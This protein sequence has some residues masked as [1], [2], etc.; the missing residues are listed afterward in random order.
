[1]S[2]RLDNILSKYTNPS[3]ENHVPLAIAA[4]VTRE[5]GL[6]YLGA[7]GAKDASVPDD[8]VTTDTTLAFYSD[9]KAVACTA[10]LQLLERGQIKSIDETVETYIPEAKNIKILQGF[11]EEDQPILKDATVKPTIRHLLTHTAGFSY[12]FFSSHYKKLLDLTG[13]PNILLSSWEQFQTPLIFEPGS[14]WHYGVNIDWVGKI[15]YNVSGQTLDQFLQENVFKQIGAPSLTFTRRPEHYA[16]QAEIH[17]RANCTSGDL[18]PLKGI[19]PEV[20]EFHAG[21][22]GLWGKLEDYMKFLEIFLHE[23]KCPSTGA[24]VLKPETVRDYAF[25]NLLPKG[26]TCTPNFQYD[27]PQLSNPVDLF[28]LFPK[29]KMSWTAN[30]FKVDVDL[31]TGRSAGSLS[32]CGLPNLYYWIDPKKGVTGMFCTQLFPFYDKTALEA[33]TEFETEVYKQFT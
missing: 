1:M 11:D 2:A 29:D 14:E 20:P 23:G 13:K 7:A 3:F 30:F 26:I 27:Q 33:L 25:S 18:I 16:N 10:L 5:N 19:H 17:Q 12:A 22:H 6:V 8:K 21:G 32:W 15:V 28:D 9:T 31:P 4:V 24:V